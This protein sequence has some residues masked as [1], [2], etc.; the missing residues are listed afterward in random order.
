MPSNDDNYLIELLDEADRREA[1]RDCVFFIEHYLKTFDPRPEAYPHNLDFKL[2][3]FQKE[4]VYGLVKAIREGYDVFDEKSRDMG[5]SWLALAVRFWMWCFEEGYQSLLG[6]RKEDYVDNRTLDSLFGKLDYFINNIRDPLILPE[7]F[8]SNKHRHH[9][10]LVNPVNGN[11]IKGESANE[12]FSRAGRYKDVLFDEIGFW[13]DAYSSW[14][15]AGDATR[16][17]QAVT[18][19]PD[20][21]SYAKI[22]RFSGQIMVRTWHWRLHPNKDD[23][24]YEY[25]KSRRTDE[26]VLHE[27]DISWEYS[28]TGTPYPEITSIT[29]GA[30]P[31][32]PDMPLYVAIDLGLDA[33]ALGWYQPIPN[34]DWIVLI[35]AYQAS[36]HIID[37]YLPFF[38]RGDCVAGETCAYCSE[39]HTFEYNASDSEFIRSIEKWKQPIFY[40][41][42]SGMSK[43]I[44]SAVSPYTILGRHNIK[45]EV[46]NLENEWIPRRDSVKKLIPHLAM[47][48]TPRTEWWLECVRSAHYPK[49]SEESQAV[50]PITKPVHDWTSHH[51]TQ[52]E[53]FAVNYKPVRKR[54]PTRQ[55]T[56]IDKN[57]V[58]HGDTIDIE[59]I[60]R[61]ANRGRR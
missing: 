23:T 52:T 2:Y 19:P 29:K 33:V 27:I 26:E 32:N 17:R 12:N 36:N 8:E 13:P 10:K 30:Y 41:D 11:V 57:G 34:T 1:R 59:K 16:C 42:P 51:R 44:E 35:E 9:M 58:L 21:P 22:L 38:G 4:Y 48:V 28:S 46:N 49:R 39:K 24:W 3:D 47:N 15:A 18:T 53:F 31:Y 45:V 54:E 14:A 60:L 7:G 25:E 5:A 55:A 40:G 20:T 56:F 61:N 6:S 43:H 50:N 37:W